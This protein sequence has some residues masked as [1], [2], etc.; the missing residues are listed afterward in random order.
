MLLAKGSH[1]A[2][3][4]PEGGLLSSWYYEK[5]PILY[6]ATPRLADGQWKLRGGAFWTLPNFGPDKRKV[7]HPYPQHGFLR[8]KMLS[9]APSHSKSEVHFA[10]H[11]GSEGEAQV[12][13]ELRNLTLDTSLTYRNTSVERIPLLVA[14]HPYFAVPPQGLLVMMQGVPDP[15]IA[16]TDQKGEAR[17]PRAAIKRT[18]AVSIYL[19][20]I[21]VVDLALEQSCTHILIWSDQQEKYLCVEP[22]FG[23]PGTFGH[24]EQGEWLGAGKHARYTVGFRFTPQ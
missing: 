5:Y 23:T 6:P 10:F 24:E 12:G 11:G 9:L 8:T 4:S 7:E 22:I 14:Y 18:G 19:Q 20:G 21:G 3:V 2:Q 15:C 13:Y 16:Y 1:A 17:F